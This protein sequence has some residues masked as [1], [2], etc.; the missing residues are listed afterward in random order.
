MLHA[1]ACQLDAASTMAIH[2]EAH[3]VAAT[4]LLTTAVR[5][6]TVTMPARLTGSL[7]VCKTAALADV[8]LAPRR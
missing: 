3:E 1:P 8:G 2:G 7:D 6:L 4:P 5:F